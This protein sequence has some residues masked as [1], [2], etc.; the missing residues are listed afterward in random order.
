AAGRRLR[1]EALERR[2]GALPQPAS[3]RLHPAFELRRIA[4][5]EAVEKRAPVELG[6]LRRVTALER[7]LEGLHIAGDDVRIEPQLSR[8][9]DEIG[10]VEVAPQRVTG[11]LEEAAGVLG[12]LHQPDLILGA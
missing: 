9:E 10:L 1:G 3:L 7:G 11:L 5:I 2:G 4:Q 8:A 6:G 12:D